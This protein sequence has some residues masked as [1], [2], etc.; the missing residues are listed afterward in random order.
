MPWC[1]KQINSVGFCPCN[2]ALTCPLGTQAWSWH[3][4]AE[5]QGI[6]L[7]VCRKMLHL[8]CAHTQEVIL[9]HW[10]GLERCW[11]C[12]NSWQEGP[13]FF[14]FIRWSL[15]FFSFLISFC[16]FCCFSGLFPCTL[17][18]LKAGAKAFRGSVWGSCSAACLGLSSLLLSLSFSELPL[19][20]HKVLNCRFKLPVLILGGVGSTKC[21][22]PRGMQRRGCK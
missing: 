13:I 3:L 18:I 2:P 21:F 7:R 10:K 22:C 8:L 15:A 5:L 16:R 12:Q 20:P 11:V 9:L 14:I 6:L 4:S 17:G 19:G 1:A